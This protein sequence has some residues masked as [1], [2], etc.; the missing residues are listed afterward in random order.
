MLLST[1]AV[2]L[3]FISQAFRET[4]AMGCVILDA[5]VDELDG[6]RRAS[7]SAWADIGAFRLAPWVVAEDVEH[8]PLVLPHVL[9]QQQHMEDIPLEFVG[10]RLFAPSV[11]G[12]KGHTEVSFRDRCLTA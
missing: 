3:L 12:A 2:L 4:S 1:N 6:G 9:A 7:F 5:Q 8:A 10:G 11:S